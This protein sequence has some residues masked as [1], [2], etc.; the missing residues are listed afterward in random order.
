MLYYL[1]QYLLEQT[2]GTSWADTLGPLRLLHYISVRSAGAAVTALL[3]SLWLGPK[4]ILWLKKL[5]FGQNYVD[6]AEDSGGLTARVLSKKGTPTMGGVLIVLVL[7][8]TALL[9]THL[10]EL[11]VLTLLSLIVLTGLGFYDDYMKITRQNNRGTA[12]WVKLGIQ[13]F[14]A[15]FIAVYLWKSSLY[16][17]LGN[18]KFNLV[19]DVMVPFYKYPVVIGAVAVGILITVFSIVGSSNAVNLTDGLDGLAI[20]CTL[21]VS[22]VFL[23]FTYVAS[24]VKLAVYLN[25]PYV[26]GAGELTV[27]CAALIGASLGFLWFNCHPAQVFMGDTGSLALGGA[28]G[29]IA[30]LIHQPFVLVIA[31]GVF[32]AEAVSVILQTGW[33]KL[34]RRLYGEPRRLFLMAPLHHHFEKKG[35]YES[36]VVTRFYI[37]SFLCAVAALSTLKLR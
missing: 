26:T 13:I 9:W 25:V 1:S 35:W 22:S 7:D 11:V 5:K 27:L 12:S 19:S 4:V 36:Q 30:V 2:A 32:V 21:M 29:I 15:A 16:S 31:G 20:G 8:I 23:V 18:T 6:K 28:L 3:L 33:F 24:N 37:L 14:L 34:T 10:N 17:V